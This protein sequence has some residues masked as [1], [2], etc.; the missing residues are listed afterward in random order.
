PPGPHG[1]RWSPATLLVSSCPATLPSS[2]SPVMLQ[3]CT[4]VRRASRPGLPSRG[5]A[6]RRGTPAAVPARSTRGEKVGHG[7]RQAEPAKSEAEEPVVL[8]APQLLLFASDLFGAASRVL[9]QSKTCT[10]RF[11]AH[12]E[13]TSS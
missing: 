8:S 2:L 6:S 12:R 11:S 5:M 3:P 10:N 13:E 1:R 9:L 7:G 4:S